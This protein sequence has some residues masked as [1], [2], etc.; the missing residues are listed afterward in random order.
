MAKIHK[1]SFGQFVKDLQNENLSVWLFGC[2]EKGQNFILKYRTT[3]IVSHIKGFI[4]NN[5]NQQGKMLAIESGKFPVISL[6]QFVNSKTDQSTF[7]KMII[8]FSIFTPLGI[9]IGMMFAAA[10]AMTQGVMLSVSA[11]TFLYV[12]AS[13]VI[14]EEF[15]VSSY[16]GMKFFM[17]LIGGMF[18]ACLTYGETFQGTSSIKN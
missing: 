18:V 14:I 10:S 11:G 3:G 9:A 7:V 5:P 1:C 13:E 12:S 16:K 17:Y 4:D 2:G 15:A 8:L 6:Q